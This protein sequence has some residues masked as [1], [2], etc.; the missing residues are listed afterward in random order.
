[1]LYTQAAGHAAEGTCACIRPVTQVFPPRAASSRPP[2]LLQT[3]ESKLLEAKN[4]A[5]RLASA[6]PHQQR[7]P[8]LADNLLL[9]SHRQVGTGVDSLR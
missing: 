1:M 9:D 6:G 3:L 2:V 8:Q 5:G 4:A 7:D